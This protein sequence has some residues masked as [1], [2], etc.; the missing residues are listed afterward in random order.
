LPEIGRLGSII[1]R[2]YADDARR[3][4]QPHFHAVDPEQAVVV[5]LPDLR[6]IAGR[7][8]RSRDVIAWASL[9]M[10]LSRLVEA[11]N[12]GNPNRQIRTNV[13]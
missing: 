12:R 9:P 13:P 5:S 3:H 10:N 7:L 2:V 8:R 11:W 4:R 1:I 6:I